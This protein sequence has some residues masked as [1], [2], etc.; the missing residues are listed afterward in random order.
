MQDGARV[1]DRARAAPVPGD[2]ARG[3]PHDL[4]L[5]REGA[6]LPRLRSAAGARIL[7]AVLLEALGRAVRRAAR[8]S[9]SGVSAGARV[10]RAAGPPAAAS[11]WPGRPSSRAARSARRGSR[12][13]CSGS[14]SSGSS[15]RG[16]GR[17]VVTAAARD[18]RHEQ[19][20]QQPGAEAQRSTAGSRR[21][22]CG[23][24][25]RSFWTSCSREH[26]HSLRFST[27]VGKVAGRGG[28][29]E[30]RSHH[31]ELLAG[32]GVHVGHPRLDLADDLA[33]RAGTQSV[34]LA[35]GHRRGTIAAGH[36]D[37]DLPRL[38]APRAPAATSTTRTSC[39]R[40]RRSATRCTC[41]ARTATTSRPRA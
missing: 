20:R 19:Q 7:V 2:R 39:G 37:P 13:A 5:A 27:A 12:L 25:F 11:R 33:V 38:P 15:R 4:R 30:Q 28:E 6:R 17:L 3:P 34:L 8:V 36:A 29:R 10:G 14:D 32:L 23:Q 41:S 35:G 22:Q 40:W 24:S 1:P 21:P 31:L 26:P 18:G 9:L 16:L